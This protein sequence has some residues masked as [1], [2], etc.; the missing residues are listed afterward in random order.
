LRV[1]GFRK[2]T[3]LKKSTPRDQTRC[4]RIHV[5][6]VPSR[7]PSTRDAPDS[8][9]RSGSPTDDVSGVVGSSSARPFSRSGSLGTAVG[10]A[11]RG[12]TR[13]RAASRRRIAVLGGGGGSEPMR[14]SRGR[15]LVV[16]GRDSP[17]VIA[18]AT[19]APPRSG[20]DTGRSRRT[21]W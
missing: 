12:P 19:L 7:R 17:I 2:G 18:V 14:T 6:A 4:S 1:R 13:R 3:G 8:P 9:G 11:G 21:S 20:G 5:H 16:G 10:A 15:T